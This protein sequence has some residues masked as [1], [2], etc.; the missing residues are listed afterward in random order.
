MAKSPAKPSKRSTNRKT[1]GNF[2]GHAP[3]AQSP[4]PRAR[5]DDT[6]EAREQ[7]RRAPKTHPTRAIGSRRKDEASKAHVRAAGP[8][9]SRG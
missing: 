4:K 2:P 1:T 8:N 7:Q 9:R 5:R 3:R 6:P